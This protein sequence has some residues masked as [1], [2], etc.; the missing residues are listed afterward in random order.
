MCTLASI[1]RFGSTPSCAATCL[2]PHRRA[3]E[4]SGQLCHSHAHWRSPTILEEKSR[5]ATGVTLHGC[6]VEQGA[7]IG[8][9]SIVLDDARVG[10]RSLVAAVRCLSPGTSFHRVRW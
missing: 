7:L 9:G 1:R 5:W 3:H 6:Y 10:A 8:I 4:R 2:H